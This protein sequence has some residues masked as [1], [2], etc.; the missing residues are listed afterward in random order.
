MIS[1]QRKITYS[2]YWHNFRYSDYSADFIGDEVDLVAFFNLIV[3]IQPT[4]RVVNSQQLRHDPFHAKKAA[5][6]ESV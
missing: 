4:I 5:N 6:A 2:F 1:A 3:I